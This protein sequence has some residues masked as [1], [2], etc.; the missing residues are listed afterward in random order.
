[1]P[2]TR[3][4]VSDAL[5]NLITRFRLLVRRAARR[6]GLSDAVLDELCQDVR[7][8]VWQALRTGEQISAAHASYVYRTALSAALDMVRRR[9]ARREEQW[10]TWREEGEAG[11]AA[12]LSVST[13]G[14]EA[15]VNQQELEA[16]VEHVV[17][18]LP[19]PRDVVVRLYLAGYGRKDMAELL[20]WTEGKTR[21]LL[22]R[23]LVELRTK[24]QEGGIGP[25]EVA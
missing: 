7:I 2:P 22:H 10:V 4:S 24:L 5:E 19:E 13:P 17:S 20:G 11:D 12:E 18:S 15:G 23:G 14:A 3:D 21:N 16:R 8:R 9:R 25:T 6:R 1:M